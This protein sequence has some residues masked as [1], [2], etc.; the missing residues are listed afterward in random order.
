MEIR[1]TVRGNPTPKARPRVTVKAQT[2]RVHAYTPRRTKAWEAKVRDEAQA[3]MQ[4]RPPW[5]G[6][7]GVE[8]WI[9]RADRRRADADNIEKGVS[10]ACNLVVW[11]DDAQVVEMHRHKGVDREN[12]RIEIRAWEMKK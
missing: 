1:F 3:A 12:P 10:D 5:T 8:L 2:G 6:P 7:V 9:W 11:V 4:G